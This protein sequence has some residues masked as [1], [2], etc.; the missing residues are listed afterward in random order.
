VLVNGRL[1]RGLYLSLGSR[2]SVRIG[3]FS[4]SRS[5]G[6]EVD[7]AKGLRVRIGMFLVLQL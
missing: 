6:E 7:E 3:S 5:E 2:V 4:E 1:K